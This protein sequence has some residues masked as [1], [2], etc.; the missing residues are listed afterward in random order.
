M[1]RVVVTGIGAVSALGIGRQKNHSALV[2]SST[3]VAGKSNDTWAKAVYQ[4]N[5][6]SAEDFFAQALVRRMDRFSKLFLAVSKF[7]IEDAGLLGISI[8][9]Y[10]TIF[11]TYWG[12]LEVTERYF[13]ELIKLGPQNASPQLFPSMVTNASLGRVAREFQLK[14][15]SSCLVGACPL[16]YSKESIANEKGIGILT[17]AA[18]EVYETNYK[19]FEA[20]G[21]LTDSP[22]SVVSSIKQ[23]QK[24]IVLGEGAFTFVFEN[25][26]Y[27]KKRGA[28]IYGEICS[29]N[30]VFAP[31]ILKP[32]N[33]DVAVARMARNIKQ[34]L[35]SAGIS[36]ED[37]GGI[38]S[39]ANTDADIIAFEKKALCEVFGSI[40]REIPMFF[41]KDYFGEI[42]GAGSSSALY[43]G[44][45]V[46]NSEDIPYG[47]C[48]RKGEY[49]GTPGTSG[50]LV[51]KTLL[52]N[53]FVIATNIQC[54]VL[55]RDRLLS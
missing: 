30:S 32:I 45:E 26:E 18:D 54:M 6:F 8:E 25:G 12:P 42:P 50:Q 27:A 28:Q 51:N 10:G 52:C 49:V 3:P 11:A 29:V 22:S 31:L 16:E 17:G 33:P 9:D 43:M 48:L 39:C 46:I 5:N 21:F 13:K 34:T 37:I 19:S 1:K 7:A 47:I 35:D 41:P 36:P 2:S 53:S 38:I 40:D 15:I 20:A 4:I 55:S 24:G 23:P 44:L 14:G